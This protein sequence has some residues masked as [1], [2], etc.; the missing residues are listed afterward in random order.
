MSNN[1]VDE[2]IDQ[3]VLNALAVHFPK[4]AAIL[5]PA[6]SGPYNTAEPPATPDEIDEMERVWEVPFPASYK[7]FLGITRGISVFGGGLQTNCHPFFH[8]YPPDDDL[9]PKSQQSVKI[10]PRPS[11]GM[12]CFADYCLE[13]DGDQALFDV[14]QGL[15][16]GEYPVY[17]YNHDVPSV[18]KVADS[19][20]EFLEEFVVG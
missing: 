6:V 3:S 1:E 9:P 17:Y 16:H 11:E 4:F 7:V 10:G 20:K 2:V 19:F 12:L 18:R 13:A 8:T 15:I 14:S 5:D